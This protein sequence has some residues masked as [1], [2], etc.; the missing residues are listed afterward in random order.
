MNTW[1]ILYVAAALAL[2]VANAFVSNWSGDTTAGPQ[3][4]DETV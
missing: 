2:L 4:E 3:E 1:A